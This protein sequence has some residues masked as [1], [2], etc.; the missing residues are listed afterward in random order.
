M[1]TL[2]QSHQGTTADDAFGQAVEIKRQLGESGAEST[3]DVGRLRAVLSLPQEALAEDACRADAQVLLANAFH[4]PH[5]VIHP[6]TGNE[7]RRQ[8]SN[9]GA[10]SACARIPRR[11]MWHLDA[12]YTSSSKCP[13]RD[14]SGLCRGRGGG[15]AVAG[16]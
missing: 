1:G 11:R 14:M 8:P 5:L 7:L 4:L 15:D 13:G 6:R 16:T 9:T 3:E 2:E 12:G 10:T